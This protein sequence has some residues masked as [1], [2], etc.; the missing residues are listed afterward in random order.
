V[1]GDPTAHLLLV[2]AYTPGQTQLTSHKTAVWLPLVVPAL[3]LWLPSSAAAQ[4]ADPGIP[5]VNTVYVTAMDR[6]AVPVTDL[7]AKDIV[8]KEGG[9]IREIVKVEPAS[10]P[11]HICIIVD[12]SGTGIFRY[13]VSNFVAQ[14]LGRAEFAIRRV[15]GQVQTVVNYTSDVEQLRT[16]ILSL[17]AGSQPPKGSQL[18]EGIFEAAREQQQSQAQRPVI[19]VLTD[20]EAEYSPLPADHVLEQ[21]RRSGALLYVIAV[22]S[23]PVRTGPGLTS[24]AQPAVPGTPS[25]DRPSD[26]LDRLADV[27]Q[28]LG[29]GPA[30]TGGRRADIGATAGPIRA[31]Q[32]IAQELNHQ[33]L[34]TYVVPAGEKLA[35]K[36]SLSSKRRGVSLRGPAHA[37]ARTP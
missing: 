8:L 17:N 7:T 37:D 13:S 24:P 25:V 19:V 1:R 14:L 4:R 34:I 22:A 23:V 20:T 32:E 26:L 16:A 12:D 2:R 31:L 10:M 6:N 5:R 9:H 35:Q 30:Q 15:I 3:M 28:V 36:L 21:L 11:L 29:D 33:Y 27:N 18:V